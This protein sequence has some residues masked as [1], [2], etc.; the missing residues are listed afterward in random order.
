MGSA[1]FGTA[2]FLRVNR[3]TI[4]YGLRVG[5]K[6]FPQCYV[7]GLHAL[8]LTER[9]M[10][11]QIVAALIVKPSSPSSFGCGAVDH[12]SVSSSMAVLSHFQQLVGYQ[13]LQEDIEY[14]WWRRFAEMVTVFFV[15]VFPQVLTTCISL[16]T[17]ATLRKVKEPQIMWIGN[18][19]RKKLPKLRVLLPELALDLPKVGYPPRNFDH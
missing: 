2:P 16:L 13:D 1:R 3:S 8:W 19:L 4:R 5:A 15:F 18:L 7:R 14:N 12:K 6:A 10:L 11:W 17:Q 9:R